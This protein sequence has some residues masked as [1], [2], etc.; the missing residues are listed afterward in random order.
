M[1]DVQCLDLREK[2]NLLVPR[3]FSPNTDRMTLLLGRT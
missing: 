3:L 2:A 1:T